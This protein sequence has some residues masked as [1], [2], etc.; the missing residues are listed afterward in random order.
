MLPFLYHMIETIVSLSASSKLSFLLDAWL[1]SV[2]AS[3]MLQQNHAI[4]Y[5]Q[6]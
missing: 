6:L 5:W 1:T 4:F 2:I 3:V